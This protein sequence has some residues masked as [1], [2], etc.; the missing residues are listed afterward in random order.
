MSD[1]TAGRVPLPAYP[2]YLVG[3]DGKVW[4]AKD[5]SAE[6]VA[7]KV[8]L[9]KHGKARV[10]LYRD[11]RAHM[12]SVPRLVL[13]AFVGPAPHKL[14]IPVH[15]DGN[16]LNCAVDNLAWGL[17]SPGIGGRGKARD[18]GELARSIKHE[19]RVIRC[20]VDLLATLPKGGRS[21]VLAYIA[22]ILGE[23]ANDPAEGDD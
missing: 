9:D 4:S 5:A 22:S 10:S 17:R 14:S 19:A 8:I 1:P 13:E 21:R 16:K 3:R 18:P 6:P 7:L 12:L 15:R 23:P 2:G 20:V 11:G